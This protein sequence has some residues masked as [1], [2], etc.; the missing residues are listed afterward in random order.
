MNSK[1]LTILSLTIAVVALVVS[2]AAFNKAGGQADVRED[3]ESFKLEIESTVTDLSKIR[4][5]IAPQMEAKL[6][7]V[8]AKGHLLAAKMY[9]TLDNNYNKA[10]EE[11][12]KAANN[13]EKARTKA[14]EVTRE[15]IMELKAG[16]TEA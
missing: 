1:F 12:S 5:E 6:Q 11:L 10:A 3:I 13:L 8:E 9:I 4:A 14:S 7:M 2:I 16:I 15:K